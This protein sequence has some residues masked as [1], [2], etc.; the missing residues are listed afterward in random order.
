MKKVLVITCRFSQPDKVGAIR[1]RGIAR[2]LERFGWHPVFILPVTPY[3]PGMKLD[4]S[5]AHPPYQKHVKLLLNREGKKRLRET[6]F[7]LPP[8]PERFYSFFRGLVEFPDPYA[9]WIPFAY[10]VACDIMERENIRHM[11]TISDPVSCHLAGYRIKRRFPGVFWLADFRD[12]WALY[13]PNRGM[14]LLEKKLERKTLGLAD[15]ISMVT[16]SL[17]KDY[18]DAFPG[19]RVYTITNGFDPDEMSM[20]MERRSGPFTIIHTGSLY[21]GLRSPEPLFKAVYELLREKGIGDISLKFYGEPGQWLMEMAG[22]HGVA[23]KVESHGRIGRSEILGMQRNCHVLFLPWNRMSE[24]K[25]VLTGKIFEYL[26]AMRPILYTGE[27]DSDIAGLLRETGA[28]VTC[29]DAQAVKKVVLEWYMEWKNLGEVRYRG[30]RKGIM[31]Y[32]H[33]EMASSFAGVLESGQSDLTC[34]R[35]DPHKKK[36]GENG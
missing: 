9:G 7:P 28:G 18:Q 5:E 36:G 24:G 27:E 32:S 20:G 14:K 4:V 30:D 13:V 15:A 8:F 34:E 2:Y 10:Y 33:V 25:K 6:A 35:K 23:G 26:A 19:K 17:S 21:G 12:P 16:P 3:P 22:K 29:P 31:K 1:S 11:I